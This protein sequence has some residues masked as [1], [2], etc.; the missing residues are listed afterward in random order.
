MQRNFQTPL[1][2]CRKTNGT[3]N[4]RRVTGKN[5]KKTLWS[6]P[7]DL[8]D[9]ML[10]KATD[11]VINFKLNNQIDRTDRLIDTYTD[12]TD[13]TEAM[14]VIDLFSGGQSWRPS[15]EKIGMIY[16]L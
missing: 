12:T 7:H 4:K 3:F 16:K 11:Q 10:T 9:E 2:H 13:N 5:I 8:I 15:V 1:R 6:I 14:Y